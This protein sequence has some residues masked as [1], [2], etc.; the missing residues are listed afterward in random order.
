MC[1][2]PDYRQLAERI[3]TSLDSQHCRLLPIYPN[4]SFH[5]F[6]QAFRDGETESCTA[7]LPSCGA[8]GLTEG[9]EEARDL[10]WRHPNAAVADRKFQFDMVDNSP[11]A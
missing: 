5:H 2:P 11:R 1:S 10:F 6:H 4:V 3:F 9:L 8:I 7:V